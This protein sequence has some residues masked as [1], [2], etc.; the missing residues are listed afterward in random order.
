M[1]DPFD[2]LLAWAKVGLV[3]YSNSCLVVHLF[4]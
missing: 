1:I 2:D 4:W 3:H